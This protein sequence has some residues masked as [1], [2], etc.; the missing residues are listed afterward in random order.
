MRHPVH[1]LLLR[2]L[3]SDQ[4]AFDSSKHELWPSERFV[5]SRRDPHPKPGRAAEPA[6]RGT[7]YRE[8]EYRN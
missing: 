7:V 6:R 5:P 4:F 3:D 1:R 2:F 8:L